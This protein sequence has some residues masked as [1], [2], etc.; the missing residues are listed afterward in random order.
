M[1]TKLLTNIDSVYYSFI[2][3]EAKEN[4]I[5]KRSVIESAIDYYMREKNKNKIKNEYEKMWQDNEY[6]NE[7]L[8]NSDYLSYL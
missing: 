4:K 3:Q 6:L 5:T 7:M 1:K 2:E 8:D